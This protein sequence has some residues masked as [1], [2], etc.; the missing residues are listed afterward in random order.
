MRSI[1]VD[2]SSEIV[3]I[4]CRNNADGD[5]TCITLIVAN[6]SL[7]WCRTRN[8][9]VPRSRWHIRIARR[10]VQIPLHVSFALSFAFTGR[11]LSPIEKSLSEAQGIVRRKSA[12]ELADCDKPHAC[13]R[14]LPCRSSAHRDKVSAVGE[15]QKSESPIQ[16]AEYLLQTSCRTPTAFFLKS[17]SLISQAI[18]PV[19]RQPRYCPISVRRLSR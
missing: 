9:R 5:G 18:S 1:T 13:L 14:H 10:H 2:R 4:C 17:K 16:H 12:F 11:R 3:L 15:H 8:S 7:E 19:P 6:R